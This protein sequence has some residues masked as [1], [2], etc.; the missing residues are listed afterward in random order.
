[1]FSKQ[2]IFCSDVSLEALPCPYLLGSGHCHES[3]C[4]GSSQLLSHITQG[5]LVDGIS[6]HSWSKDG[7]G[8]NQIPCMRSVTRV[9]EKKMRHF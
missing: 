4:A 1:M 7:S 3:Y 9:Q 8:A 5:E 2:V 6:H